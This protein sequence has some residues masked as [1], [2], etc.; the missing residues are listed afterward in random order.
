VFTGIVQELGTVAAV[1]DREGGTRIR[2]LAG[3]AGE[4][5]E[6]DSV[7]VNGVCLTAL[8]PAGGA[9]EAD[10]SSETTSRTSLGRLGAGEPVNL[11]LPVRP[12]DRLGGHIVQGHVDAVGTVSSVAEDGEGRVVRFTVPPALM[13]YVV[14]KG[15]VTVDGVSLTVAEVDDGG[16][17]VSLIPETLARTTLGG[18]TKGRPVNLEVDVIAK[19]VE[20][21]LEHRA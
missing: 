7:A 5:R 6:G 1:A 13:R 12:S 14:E 19:H 2:V 3:L 4:L 16:F 15:S 21:L 17:A 18:A 11:E 9:F 20:R 8:A 10:L